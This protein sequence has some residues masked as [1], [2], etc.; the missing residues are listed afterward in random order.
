MD[1]STLALFAIA[2]VALAATP[3]PD[4]LLIAPVF[5]Q[6]FL[7]KLLNDAGFAAKPAFDSGR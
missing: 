7:T 3:G 2:C 4:M 1:W 5:R 6:G